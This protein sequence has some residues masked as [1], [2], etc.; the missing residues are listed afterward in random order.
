M[1]KKS[2][3]NGNGGYV[4][5]VPNAVG[6]LCS[7]NV[8]LVGYHAPGCAE[9]YIPPSLDSGELPLVQAVLTAEN[10][11]HVLIGNRDISTGEPFD[12]F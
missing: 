5:P 8:Q 6:C 9:T 11:C 4:A 2:N 7:W 1:S 10:G 12:T 3:P